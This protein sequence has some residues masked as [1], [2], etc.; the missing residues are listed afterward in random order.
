MGLNKIDD[1]GTIFFFT[2]ASSY[3]VEEIEESKK[4]SIVM[5][6]KNSQNYLMIYRIA[7]LA[8]NISKMK[9]LRSFLI[10]A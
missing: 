3:K 10:K 7:T 1:D 4:V 6:N 9:E 2:K 8:Y 5:A